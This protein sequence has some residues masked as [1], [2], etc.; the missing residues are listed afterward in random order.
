MFQKW[1]IKAH[2]VVVLDGIGIELSNECTEYVNEGR[3]FFG[4]GCFQHLFKA[5]VITNGDQEDA[6]PR[7]IKRGCFEI[8][9]QAVQVVI[10]HA[11]KKDPACK[12]EVLFDGSDTIVGVVQSRER[13]DFSVQASRCPSK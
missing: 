2:Q 8:E 9:L 7:W 6:A 3:F 10:G 11:A 4:S 13:R 5:A 1:Q 12:H